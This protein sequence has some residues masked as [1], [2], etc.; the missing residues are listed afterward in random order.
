M[1][2]KDFLIDDGGNRQAIETIG[3]SFPELDI[4]PSLTLVVETV[5]SVDGGALMV[6]AKNE[7]V[8]GILDLI[9]QEQADCL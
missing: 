1:H 3:E 5:D 6:S 4:V 7:K 2:G 8:L 9:G